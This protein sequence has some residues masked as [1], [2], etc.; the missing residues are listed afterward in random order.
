V[1]VF[2]NGNPVG[3]IQITGFNG[4]LSGTH[5][6]NIGFPYK[7]YIPKEFLVTGANILRIEKLGHPYGATTTDYNYLDFIFDYLELDSLSAPATEPLHGRLTYLGAQ[8]GGPK[9]SGTQTLGDPYWLEWLGVAYS[10]NPQR[11]GFGDAA[12]WQQPDRLNWIK[13][14]KS[15]NMRVVMDYLDQ[16]VDT[17]STNGVLIPALQTDI[18]NFWGLYGSYFQFYELANEP[19]NYYSDGPNGNS[20]IAL[21]AIAN[22]M[23]SSLTTWKGQGGIVEAP[24]Y[25]YGGSV[26]SPA[27]WDATT[28]NRQNLEYAVSQCQAS[29]GH[30]YAGSYYEASGGNL[31]E[32]YATYSGTNPLML[33]GYPVPMVVTELGMNTGQAGS[34]PNGSDAGVS[35]SALSL[36]SSNCNAS[37]FDREIRAHLAI[38]DYSIIYAAVASDDYGMCTETVWDDPSTWQA[39]PWMTQPDVY[40]LTIFRQYALA[41]ATHG[42]P[43]PYTYLQVDGTNG[44]N[45]QL[46][47]FRAVDTSKL[48]PLPVS[49]ATSNKIL[50]NFVNFDRIPHTMQIQVTMPVAGTYTGER[51]G[52]DNTYAAAHSDVSLTASPTITITESLPARGSVQYILTPP[53]GVIGYWQFTEGSGTTTADYSGNGENG[54]L[55]NSPTWISGVFGDALSFN[56]ASSYVDLGNTSAT[57]PLKPALPVTVSAWI[58]PT[59]AGQSAAIFAADRGDSGKYAG[60]NLQVSSGVL[61]CGY[62]DGTGGGSSTYRRTKTG[63]TSLSAGQWYHVAGVIQG[64]TN[65]NLYVNGVDDG[66]SYSGSG[67]VMAYTTTSSKIGASSGSGYFS[68]GIDDVRV[69]NTVLSSTAVGLLAKPPVG[70]WRFDEG[71]GSAAS[72]SGTAGI[73]GTLVSSPTWTGGWFGNALSFNGVNTYVNL[74]DASTSSPLK[75]ALPISVSAW[76]MLTS[77]GQSAA[78]FNADRGDSSKYAGYNLALASGVLSC[79]YGDG[80]GGGTST[81]RRTKIGTTVLAAGQWYHVAG[82]IQ[83][84]TNMSL[85]VNGVDDGG[86]YSGSGGTMG[87]TTT[88][89]KIGGGNGNAGTGFVNGTIDDV[90]VYK[91]VLS[92]GEVETLSED[93]DGLIAPE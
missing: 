26:G 63:T 15:M 62:G 3:I 45:G 4:G 33:N 12:E 48:P 10:G 28:S 71:T 34:Y 58:K 87:Y 6:A 17:D 1:A 21:E 44:A 27:G 24:G 40:R 81:Y 32:T 55:K 76:I 64:A 20:L 68:G 18:N 11:A 42:A 78:I 31:A 88:S 93:D 72:D 14:L 65:M 59:S 80:T 73:A 74:N 70:C 13:M 49:G 2:S 38:A 16:T 77:T 90:R 9:I 89:S 8:D 35:F 84:G 5:A 51:F 47:Y 30:C 36:D 69:D 75:P 22:Y 37:V 83:G 50:L 60:Y 79:G 25:T 39:N 67:G 82:V 23:N 86:T 41:Y 46:V 52:A 43:L 85:Y 66:G 56:G 29:G 61:S 92:P 53:A 91:R 7:V 57:G 19:C 54:T